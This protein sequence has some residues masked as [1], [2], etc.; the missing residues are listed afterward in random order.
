LSLKEKHPEGQYGRD[1]PPL[2]GG[3]EQRR[4]GGGGE[5]RARQRQLQVARDKNRVAGQP[6]KRIQEDGLAKPPSG[7]ENACG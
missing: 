5:R 2:P 1:P 4:H 7:D 3:N 6:G